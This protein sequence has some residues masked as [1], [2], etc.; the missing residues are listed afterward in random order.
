MFQLEDVEEVKKKNILHSMTSF[1]KI[2][3]FKNTVQPDRPKMTRRRMR[4]V[5]WI[6][7]ATNTHSQ[8][9]ILIAFPQL[10][11]LHGRASMLR[12][13]YILSCLFC[14]EVPGVLGLGTG[15]FVLV[16]TV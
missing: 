10:Q 3:P 5:C 4:I 14:G 11:W 2:V 1:P 15:H 16:V 7:K 6:P 8:Y 12:Y 9:V 13:T